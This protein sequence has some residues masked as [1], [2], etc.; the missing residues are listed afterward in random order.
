M[1]DPKPKAI[2]TTTNSSQVNNNTTTCTMSWGNMSVATTTPNPASTSV[3]WGTMAVASTNSVNEGPE[4]TLGVVE[5]TTTSQD[6]IIP[7]SLPRP[8]QWLGSLTASPITS[9]TT[10]NGIA[11]APPRRAPHLAHLRAHSLGSAENYMGPKQGWNRNDPFDAEWANIA[12]K[13]QQASTNPFAQ[14]A[15]KAFEVQ[16]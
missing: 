11:P 8:E 12:A 3:S 1:N 7:E 14:G 2:T 4:L 13:T 10:S 5:S 6:I 9:N 15:V 16:M